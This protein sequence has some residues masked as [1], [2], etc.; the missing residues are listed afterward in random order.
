MKPFLKA[1]FFLA[2]LTILDFLLRK[3]FIAVF[4][5]FSFPHEVTFLFMFSLFTL[6]SW[7]I[8]KQ[9]C[10]RDGI[11]MHDLGISLN[12]RNRFDFMWGFL[13]GVLLWAIVSI[14]QS[15]SAGFSWVLRPDVNLFNIIYGLVF[16]FIADLGTEL[17]TRGY[18]LTRFKDSFGAISAIIIMVFF[19]GLKSF[20]FEAQGELLMYI[21]LIPALHTVFFSIIY[22]KTKRLGAAVG[23]HTGANFVTISIFDLRVEQS[24]QPIPAG[25]FQSS[26]ELESLSLTALQ[27]PY[28][29]IA[30]LFSVAVYVWWTK[31]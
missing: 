23:V 19:V 27:L 22:F 31:K 20:S 26:V 28:V 21:I 4:L 24:G 10:K 25:I 9:F 12:A 15:V 13:I 1:I 11:S 6:C 29:I 2:I 30:L 17:Y 7:L 8:T 18:P 16:I 14:V 3:G 5:P